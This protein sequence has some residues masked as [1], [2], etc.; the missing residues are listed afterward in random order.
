VLALRESS[1]S[2]AVVIV[3]LQPGGHGVVDVVKI[4]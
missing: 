1:R 2:V 4:A 3:L